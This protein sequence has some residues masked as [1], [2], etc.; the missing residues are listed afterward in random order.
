MRKKK[1]IVWFLA[2]AVIISLLA[3]CGSGFGEEA[4]GRKDTVT[5][6]FWSDEL[7]ENYGPYLQE[8]FPDVNFEFYVITNSTDFY[9]F[10]ENVNPFELFKMMIW[11]VDGY[12][13]EKQMNNEP[14][15]LET[16]SS[17]FA[18]WTGMLK[19]IAYKEEYL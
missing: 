8:S 3:G 6:A 7:T 11:L 17:V 16:I 18:N 15:C 13:H 2:G 5:V 19:Q 4:D 14:L 1:W 12:V 9:K 10:K